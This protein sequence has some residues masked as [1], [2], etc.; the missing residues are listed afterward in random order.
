MLAEKRAIVQV[1]TSREQ[2]M[3]VTYPEDKAAVKEQ[4]AALIAQS[5]YPEKLWASLPDR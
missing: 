4:L 5:R 2:W 3:G 1:L